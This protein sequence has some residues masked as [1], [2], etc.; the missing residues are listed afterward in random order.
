MNIDKRYFLDMA[1]TKMIFRGEQTRSASGQPVF[2][3]DPVRPPKSSKGVKA[4]DPNFR[5]YIR[6]YDRLHIS[7]ISKKCLRMV[8]LRVFH[9]LCVGA[10]I[11]V[12]YVS[13]RLKLVTKQVEACRSV[14]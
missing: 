7:K 8:K 2:I 4:H 5:D 11:T 10:S 1:S 14:R 12:W 9:I 13:C 3:F 6:R